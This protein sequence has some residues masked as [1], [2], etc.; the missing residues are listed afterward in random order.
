MPDEGSDESSAFHII[1]MDLIIQT[2]AGNQSSVGSKGN[3][4]REVYAAPVV[5]FPD[6]S[7]RRAVDESHS[8][9][10]VG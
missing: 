3:A 8:P 6:M 5:I 4:L 10:A 9:I 7:A 2:T 1:Q